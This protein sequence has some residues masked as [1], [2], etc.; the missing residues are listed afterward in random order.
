MPL[1]PLEEQRCYGEAFRHVHAL[2]VEAARAD[3]LAEETA[4]LLVGGLTG[5][6]L[7]PSP[8]LSARASKTSPFEGRGRSPATALACQALQ[9]HSQA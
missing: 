9:A 2:R 4:R 1:L 6:G 3:E 7:V 8:T 5:G